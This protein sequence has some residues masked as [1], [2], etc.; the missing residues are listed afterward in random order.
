MNPDE[1]LRA[2]AAWLLTE[3]AYERGGVP[4]E[5]LTYMQ[6]HIDDILAPNATLAAADFLR[7]HAG[8]GGGLAAV[9]RDRAALRALLTHLTGRQ[10]EPSDLQWRADRPT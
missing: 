7:E 4:D 2:L 10:P 3:D 5:V 1:A 9:A 8:A 6:D